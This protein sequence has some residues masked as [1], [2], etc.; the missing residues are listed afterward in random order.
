MAVVTMMLLGSRWHG[1]RLSAA[2]ATV[3]QMAAASRSHASGSP[4]SIIVTTANDVP[5]PHHAISR[6][7]ARTRRAHAEIGASI[8]GAL[9]S[10]AVGTSPSRK[11]REAPAARHDIMLEHA[12]AVGADATSP[13]A[14]TPRNFRRAPRSAAYGPAVN[15]ARLTR[16]AHKLLPTSSSTGHCMVHRSH[17]PHP[18]L[19]SLLQ[20]EFACVFIRHV[21]FSVAPRD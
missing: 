6:P 15:R 3:A 12:A 13:C 4:R 14:M 11:S 9:K 17:S 7:G 18:F 21:L 20:S 10:S 8:M 19:R 1:V 5:A 2:R 16:K